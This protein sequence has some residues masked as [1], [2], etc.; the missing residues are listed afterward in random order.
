MIIAFFVGLLGIVIIIT[1]LN[2]VVSCRVPLHGS[3]LHELGL[4]SARLF[5]LTLVLVLRKV[6]K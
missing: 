4:L 3:S 5:G 1:I 6:S 2:I